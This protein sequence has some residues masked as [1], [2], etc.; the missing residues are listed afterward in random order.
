MCHNSQRQEYGK[1][2]RNPM[3][4]RREQY[5]ILNNK[6]DTRAH[7]GSENVRVCNFLS[8]FFTLL[9][10]RLIQQRPTSSFSHFRKSQIVRE[11]YERGERDLH[12][13][14]RRVDKIFQKCHRTFH[15]KRNSNCKNIKIPLILCIYILV[16]VVKN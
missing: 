9:F 1:F 10:T 8:F 3:R 5:I 7:C 6:Y 16:I 13:V 4:A 2:N 12:N 14:V 15:S 11:K